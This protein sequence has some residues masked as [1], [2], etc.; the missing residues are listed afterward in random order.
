VVQQVNGYFQ[1]RANE[2]R[3]DL[4]VCTRA[5]EEQLR[6]EPEAARERAK[7]ELARKIAEL[8]AANPRP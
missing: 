6:G 2:I 4:Q 3:Y 5:L 8:E 7:Q 1:S